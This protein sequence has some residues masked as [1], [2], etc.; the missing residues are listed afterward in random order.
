MALA[1]TSLGR[2]WTRQCI[3]R[4]RSW[5]IIS[6]QVRT[7][8]G[9]WRWPMAQILLWASSQRKWAQ[10]TSA[11]CSQNCKG[12]YDLPRTQTQKYGKNGCGGRD[13]TPQVVQ[14]AENWFMKFWV[15]WLRWLF[16]H[17]QMTCKIAPWNDG[18]RFKKMTC[19]LHIA[20]LF[21]QKVVQWGVQT[22]AKKR[23]HAW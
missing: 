13:V 22:L 8:L 9:C 23:S 3:R 18:T 2:D 14:I 4:E 16:T 17:L 15:Q 19:N 10:R 7:F 12:S 5:G 6:V 21:A 11:F 20:R 1:S